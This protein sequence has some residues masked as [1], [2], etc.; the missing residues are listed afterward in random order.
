MPTITPT[1]G[2]LGQEGQSIVPETPAVE[3][4]IQTGGVPMP[5]AVVPEEPPIDL[6]GAQ[7]DVDAAPAAEAPPIAPPDSEGEVPPSATDAKSAVEGSEQGFHGPLEGFVGGAQGDQGP[8]EGEGVKIEPDPASP[9]MISAEE[10]PAV[11]AG[12]PPLPGAEVLPTASVLTAEEQAPPVADL[13]GQPPLPG[14]YVQ[15]AAPAAN[16]V[17]P[18]EL[19]PAQIAAVP[20]PLATVPLPTPLAESAPIPEPLVVSETSSTEVEGERPYK[21]LTWEELER[22]I[23][24]TELSIRL[25]EAESDRF[26]NTLGSGGR[27]STEFDAVNVEIGK[28][29][30]DLAQLNLEKKRK[31]AET[32]TKPEQGPAE[33]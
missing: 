20:E 30:L 33:I 15:E 11:P 28:L 14:A 29:N 25:R 5:K 32:G 19:P 12:Q 18:P 22:K 23:Q 17:L 10:D 21:D 4:P 16:A 31:L 1:G 8:N 9:P 2:E 24:E 7:A 13:S 27:D 26:F 3:V 6:T